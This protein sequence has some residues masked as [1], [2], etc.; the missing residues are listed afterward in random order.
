MALEHFHFESPVWLWGMAVL[1][2]VWGLIHTVFYRKNTPLHRLKA[3]ID[4]DLLPHLLIR[5]GRGQRSLWT[6]LLLWSVL[7]ALLMGALAG[8]RWN[9]HEIETLTPDQN[10]IIL[11]DLSKSMDGEDVKP[12]RLTRARQKIEDI[13][14][15]AQGI[16]IALIV[17]AADPHMITPLTDDMETI[18]HFLPSLET[19]LAYVQGSKLSP[20]LTMA[21]RLFDT[22]SSHNKSVLILTDGDFEDTSALALTHELAQKGIII[23]T[24]GVGTEAG[25][26]LQDDKGNFIKKKGKTVLSKLEVDKLRD[27]S[28]AGKGQYL[29]AHYSDR[30]IR[31]ILTQ[32]KE[33]ATAEETTHHKIQQWEERFYLLVFPLMALL[34]LWFRKGF[35]FVLLLLCLLPHK[36]RAVDF[37]HYFK[38]EA[39]LGKEALERGEYEVAMQQFTDPYQQGVVQ[40]KAGNFAEAEKL[41]QESKAMYNLGNALAKQEKLEEAIAAYENVLKTYP[42]HTHARYNLEIV[43]KLLEQKKQQEEQQQNKDNEQENQQNQDKDESKSGDSDQQQK[44]QQN[45]DGLEPDN[46]E[47]QENK[48]NTSEG[49]AEKQEE[50]QKDSPS[51]EK[52]D[53]QHQDSPSGEQEEEERL[54]SPSEPMQPQ[55]KDQEGE[56]AENKKAARMQKDMDADQWLNRVQNDP[57]SF[58]KNQ[59]YI[60]SHRNSTIEGPDPW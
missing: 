37:Q 10:L 45:K 38:N 33:R 19:D 5:K 16:K 50:S 40:Y 46:S 6:S 36:A 59:F 41:F 42:D 28:K 39:Q 23:H 8:P 55:Q 20:A 43:K 27:L 11:L 53:P 54:P 26:P 3:V 18:R 30:D 56:S 35:V 24:M 22:V 7:W 44:D 9:Y 57:K 17:F 47:K 58:L 49:D 31:A 52:K 51:S 1:P 48:E 12:S 60:E 15:L 4:K 25:T 32:I 29:E 14:N 21:S 2:F 13:L 34:L